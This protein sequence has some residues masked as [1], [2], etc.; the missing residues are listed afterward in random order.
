MRRFELNRSKKKLDYKKLG[1]TCEWIEKQLTSQR[2]A[3]RDNIGK[4]FKL[5]NL[6][7]SIS[8]SENLQLVSSEENMWQAKIDAL[9]VE[10]STPADDISDFI[11]ENQ[12]KDML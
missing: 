5:S 2:T 10:E 8:I 7:K 4:V 12:V 11:N 9:S 1:Q 6:L 3:D